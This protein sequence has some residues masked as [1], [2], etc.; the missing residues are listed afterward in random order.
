MPNLR[1]A[2]VI[3]MFIS[4][5]RT[6]GLRH[7]TIT[8]YQGN[9]SKF[10]E[11]AAGKKVTAMSD[12]DLVLIDA[13]RASSRDKLSAKSMYHEAGNLKRFLTWCLQ[14]NHLSANPLATSKFTPPAPKKRQSPTLEQVNAILE[15]ASSHHLPILAAI[16]FTGMR[17]GEARNLRVDDV[18]LDGNWIHIESRL[19]AETKSGE[20][21]KTPIHPRLHRILE[22]LPKKKSGYYFTALPS[23]R[24]PLGG[25]HLN[26]KHLNT[27]FIALLKKLKLPFGRDDGFTV[28]SLRRFFRTSAVSA[29]VPE[30]VVDMWIG[31]E[32]DKRSVQAIYFDLSDAASQNFITQVN[33]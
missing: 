3:E 14:R 19:G 17:S 27:S 31:H 5:C 8:K 7:K 28:H 33:F 12:I 26:P 25:H 4:H 13:Y 16:A 9:L 15:K 11:F 24:Y 21:R 32:P 22:Q 2:E 23:N 29:N 30:R 18:D 1:M 10:A 6:E 20:S